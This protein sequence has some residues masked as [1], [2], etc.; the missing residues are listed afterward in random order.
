MRIEKRPIGTGRSHVLTASALE[1]ALRAGAIALD[2][3]LVRGSARTF[4]SAE[5]WPPTPAAPE[6]RLYIVSGDVPSQTAA[7]ARAAI[8][9]QVLPAFVAWVQA[10]LTLP[11]NAPERQKKQQFHA[12]ANGQVW[13]SNA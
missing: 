5:F 8:S 1:L 9:T 13:R 11:A 2:V 6:Q 4:F 7:A 3:T 10:L 12:D